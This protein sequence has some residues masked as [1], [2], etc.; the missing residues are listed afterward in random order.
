MPAPRTDLGA[1]EQA[2]HALEQRLR[3]H[4]FRAPEASDLAELGLGARELAAA[5]RHGRL[6]RLDTTVVV[7]PSAP[8]RAMAILSRLDQPFTASAARQA[9]GTTRR[10]AI[11][12]LEHLDA[13]GWTRPVAHG[14]RIVVR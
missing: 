10:T 14:Q 8:A 9:L 1:A 7:L 13:R 6:L 4:P 3:D 11:P 12:L 2:L 5:E